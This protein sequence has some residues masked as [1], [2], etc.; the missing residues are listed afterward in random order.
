VQLLAQRFARSHDVPR[1][2]LVQPFGGE[3]VVNGG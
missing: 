1:G 2:F 3:L